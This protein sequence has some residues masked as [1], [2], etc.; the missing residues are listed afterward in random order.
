MKLRSRS[1][2]VLRIAAILVF[3]FAAVGLSTAQI[4]V[5]RTVA[6]VNDGLRTELI[7]YSDALWQ[8]ALQPNVPLDPPRPDDL[9]AAVLRLVDQRLFA[10]EAERLPRTAPTKAQIDAEIAD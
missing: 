7:T 3:G 9:N 4:V 6:T 8:L 1:K 10:L 5:D 2:V